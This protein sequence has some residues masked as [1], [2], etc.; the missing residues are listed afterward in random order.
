MARELVVDTGPGSRNGE[1][2]RSAVAMSQGGI[3]WRRVVL[4]SGSF[5]LS[6]FSAVER[7]GRC[8]IDGG[9]KGAECRLLSLRGIDGRKEGT[10]ALSIEFM[11]DR[12]EEGRNG[13]A[14]HRGYIGS[15]QRSLSQP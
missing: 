12:R 3:A 13:C 9:K 5:G 14:A 8:G 7:N 2:L 11:W 10:K 4:L 1:L 15:P 6:R